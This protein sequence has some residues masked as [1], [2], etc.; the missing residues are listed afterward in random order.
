[1]LA[2]RITSLDLTDRE[3]DKH[4]VTPWGRRA[5]DPL[6][7][8]CPW[9]GRQ[10]RREGGVRNIKGSS[11]LPPNVQFLATTLHLTQVGL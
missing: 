4:D 1:M 5:G 7:E 9:E 11:R 3:G 2:G 6:A 10:G 8:R